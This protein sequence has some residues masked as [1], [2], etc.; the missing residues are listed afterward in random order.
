MIVQRTRHLERFLIAAAITPIVFLPSIGLSEA[1]VEVNF[2]ENTQLAQQNRQNRLRALLEQGRQLADAKE[3][4]AATEIYQEAARLDA[5]NPKIF[6]GIGYLEAQQENY[7]AAVWAY[8]RAV[9]LAPDNAEFYYALGHTLAKAGNYSEATTAYFRAT[10]LDTD[11]IE[12]Y[13][14]LGAV[15]LR[16]NDPAGAL[17]IYQKL[18][19]IEPNHGEANAIVG[20]LLVRQGNYPAAIAH[21][22]EVIRIAPQE[23][24]A[25]FD[26]TT[27]YQ[28]QGQLSQAFQT[29][30]TFLQRYPNHSG[31]HY[32]KGKLLQQRGQIEA[33]A[34]AYKKAVSLNSKP[35]SALVALGEVQLKQKAYLDATVTYRRLTELVPDNP[36][37]YYNLGLA[38]KGRNRTR[39]ARQAFQTA[40]ELFRKVKHQDG[41][42]RSQMQLRI[43]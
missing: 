43:L 38:L 21:L 29:I 10:E 33:A 35:V 40:Y 20:S 19:T 25:W 5:N 34:S 4:E 15:L 27:A 30:E 41:K 13:L 8:R 42:D 6:S 28:Q 17:T 22:K 1:L 39:E 37:I 3:Y 9:E 18:L 7:D 36:S 23:S 11:K 2:Q 24:S 26:L 16:Q 14:G 31:G 12:A 32:H